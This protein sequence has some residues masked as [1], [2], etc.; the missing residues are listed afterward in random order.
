MMRMQHEDKHGSSKS[1][2]A[3]TKGTRSSTTKKVTSL[4]YE[5]VATKSSKKIRGG[6]R[7]SLHLLGSLS[8]LSGLGG[9]GGKEL[10]LDGR[11]DSSLGDDDV[12]EK[13]VQLLQ[14]SNQR[15]EQVSDM[16]WEV[17]VI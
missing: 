4:P 3:K 13:L 7:S 14:Q 1:K 2:R 15:D 6:S 12:T 16:F 10:R 17:E 11:Q 9:L 8:T 5:K